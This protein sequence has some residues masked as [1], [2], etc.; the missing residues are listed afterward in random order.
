MKCTIQRLQEECSEA[1]GEKRGVYKMVSER[2]IRD[3]IR[4]LRSDILGFNAPII[5]EDGYYFYSNPEYSIFEEYVMDKKA[6][7]S[8]Y[9]MLLVNRNSIKTSLVNY[10]LQRLA[11]ELKIELPFEISL[12]LF[13]ESLQR[14]ESQK[15]DNVQRSMYISPAASK[16]ISEEVK[17]PDGIRF[18]LGD[19]ND[20]EP[21]SSLPINDISQEDVLNE[22]ELIEEEEYSF[23]WWIIM[24][25]IDQISVAR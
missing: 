12:E 16:S 14:S 25:N 9:E 8:I 24:D 17:F 18:M 15:S 7:Y 5:Y 11:H 20:I 19:V 22:V 23:P 6:I 21:V 10:T 13:E 3:D 4:V 2:T 1:L